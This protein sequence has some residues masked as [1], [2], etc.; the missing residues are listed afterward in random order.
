MKYWK[1]KLLILSEGSV[2]MQAKNQIKNFPFPTNR[3][4]DKKL[5]L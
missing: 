5:T 2:I 4:F 1:M 3:F